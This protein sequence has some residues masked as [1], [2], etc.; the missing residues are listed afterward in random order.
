M[1]LRLP[2]KEKEHPSHLWTCRDPFYNRF[3]HHSK[4]LDGN[5][6]SNIDIPMQKRQNPSAI[7]IE[8]CIKSSTQ[9]SLQNLL[10]S[11]DQIMNHREKEIPLTFLIAKHENHW[12]SNGPLIEWWTDWFHDWTLPMHTTYFWDW[13]IQ[14]MKITTQHQLNS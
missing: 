2:I 14:I 6:S 3:F 1:W 9:R 7:A 12:Q 8:F 5:F 13:N 10:W 11:D 4:I